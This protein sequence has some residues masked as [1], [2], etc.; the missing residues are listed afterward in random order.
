MV[1]GRIAHLKMEEVN[2][3]NCVFNVSDDFDRRP[4]KAE[5]K[6]VKEKLIILPIPTYTPGSRLACSNWRG[7]GPFSVALICGHSEQ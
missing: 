3:C 2:T 7:S 5:K 6:S 1:A 4:H